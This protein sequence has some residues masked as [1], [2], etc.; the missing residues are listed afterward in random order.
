VSLVT[1]PPADG[2][3]AARRLALGLAL[4]FALSPAT[5]FGYLA[6]P[7]GL[8]GWLALTGQVTIPGRL[9]PLTRAAADSVRSWRSR[10]GLSG[11]QVQT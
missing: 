9:V 8:Y 3:A 2:A 10:R 11:G 5:R 1:R 7:A 4:M 6:Y